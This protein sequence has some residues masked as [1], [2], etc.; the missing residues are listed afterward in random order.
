M[1]RGG[2]KRN[3]KKKKEKKE[4]VPMC[5]VGTGRERAGGKEDGEERMR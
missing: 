3:R 1:I 4:E 2:E 5:E